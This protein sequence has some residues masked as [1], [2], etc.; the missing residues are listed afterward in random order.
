VT[1]L[2]DPE[3]PKRPPPDPEA[4]VVAIAAGE[5]RGERGR[6]R[7]GFRLTRGGAV[8]VLVAAAAFL[9]VL[10]SGHAAQPL[11]AL[12][13]SEL[14]GD[15][16]GSAAGA[17]EWP[18][19]VF[20]IATRP[21]GG[22]IA[23]ASSVPLLST[24]YR[25]WGAAPPPAVLGE[26]NR[27]AGEPSPTGD[28][29]RAIYVSAYTAG[30]PAAFA[31]LL[32]LVTSTGLNAMVIDIKDE[33]GYATYNTGVRAYHEAGAVRV[34]IRELEGLLHM[35]KANGV[36]TIARLVV[37][38]DSAL[39]RANPDFA[40]KTRDGRIWRD[41]RGC[42]W[43]DPF[44]PEVWEYN[45][46]LAVEAASL[47]FDEI[48]YDYVR[49]PTDGN[50]QDCVFSR[51]SGPGNANRIQAINEF[52]S[53]GRDRL[54]PYG[55]RTSADVFGIICST[56][57][58]S[59][60][61][62]VLEDVAALVDYVSPMIYPSHYG[63]GHFGLANPNAA[64]YATVKGA[65]SDALKRLGPEGAAQLRPW[66]QD[67]TLGSPPYGAAEVLDQIRATHELGI[68]GW[69]LWNPHNRYNTA[70]LRTF[71][72]NQEAYLRGGE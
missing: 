54:A 58:D 39:A 5:K 56:R 3:D 23:A 25:G 48:Q 1:L 15:A 19:W 42:A 53:Y 67:F 60:L 50:M 37:F 47:G 43:T 70:A 2:T 34:R 69:L 8:T 61:G 10:L 36:Y 72:A 30:Q 29:A 4:P 33:A 12:P 32:D 31:A 26:E 41:H 49:F 55:A 6:R 17:R 45:I 68:K 46:D 28:E 20:G 22:S 65:L 59:S 66:L 62:Q 38:N 7:R 51:P 57:Y 63:P 64:P 24:G 18:S 16:A 40:V 21:A 52:L 9:G 11:A 35:A 14:I 44:R 13:L 27:S 71:T